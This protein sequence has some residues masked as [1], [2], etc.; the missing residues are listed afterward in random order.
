MSTN[1]FSR[2]T[3]LAGTAA[4]FG[5]AMVHPLL[6]DDAPPPDKKIGI[7]LVGIGSLSTGQLIPALR[8]M[9]KYCKCVAFVTGHRERNLPVAA[10]LGI[11]PEHVYTYDNF[12]T[13]KDNPAVDVVYVVLPNSMH[14]EYT[15]RAAQAGKH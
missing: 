6:G 8:G 3:F 4:A 13:I 15:I 7:A 14:C 10:K 9:T 12:D 2:R 5:A 1:P 11:A